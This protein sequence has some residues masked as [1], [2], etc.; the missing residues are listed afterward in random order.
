MSNLAIQW[1]ARSSNAKTGP[2]PVSTT[3]KASCPSDC[4]FKGNGCYAEAG[5]LGMM[6]RKMSEAGPNAAFKSGVATVKTI[7]WAALCDKVSELPQDQLWRH[8]QAG[9]LP[10]DGHGNIDTDMVGALVDA[11]AGKRGFTYTH[12]NV[13]QNAANRA[14]VADA[15]ARGMTINVSANSPRHADALADLGLPVV[16]VLAADVDGHT[17][18]T[19]DTPQGRKIVVCPATYRD[20]VSCASCGL[21]AVS[22]RK[23][24]V[25][26]PAHGASKRRASAVALA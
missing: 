18:K 1:S 26:F 12:H 14:V 17:T 13:A 15:N 2:M 6:W 21:C 3:D 8:N 7:D 16:S 22:D 4:P 10:Q 9:D 5:P 19:V 25:G 11:N 24:I 23:V 20:D